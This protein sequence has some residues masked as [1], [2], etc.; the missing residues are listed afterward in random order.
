M[1]IHPIRKVIIN[2]IR[3]RRI[4]QPIRMKIHPN[5]IRIKLAMKIHPLKVKVINPKRIMKKLQIKAKI[6]HLLRLRIIYLIIVQPIR[7]CQMKTSSS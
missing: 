5:R 1:K 7:M 2:P 4:K 6:I 3:R